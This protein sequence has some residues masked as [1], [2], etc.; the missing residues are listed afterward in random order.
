MLRDAAVAII[1]SRLGNRGSAFDATIVT[2][3]QAKQTDLEQ[4]GQL[5]WFL[6][7]QNT[8]LSTTAATKTLAAP[9]GFLMEDDY[10][11][12]WVIGTDGVYN[13]IKKKDY[14][15]MRGSEFHDENGLPEA[16]SLQGSTFYFWPTPDIAYS[17]QL[18]YYVA[19]TV[20]S[21]NVTNQWL[22]Y[23]PGLLIAETGLEIAKSFRDDEAIKYFGSARNEALRRLWNQDE[24][25]RQAGLEAV[26]GG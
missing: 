8:A 3:M 13:R 15:T 18:N 20:L 12:F 17:L 5:R 11:G 25:R 22:T 4:E 6:L 7:T 21:S 10:A 26:M 23:A 2:E 14:D 24:A 1:A 9:S 16:Y 19:D